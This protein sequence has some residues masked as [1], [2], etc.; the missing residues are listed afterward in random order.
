M[1]RTSKSFLPFLALGV[2]AAV[3]FTASPAFAQAATD[4]ARADRDKWLGLAAALA[5]GLS[6]LGG[7]IG[8]GRA[9]GSALEGIARNP[10]A[11]GKI[12]VPMIVGLALIESLVIYGLLIAFQLFGKIG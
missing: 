7:A 10:Q 3:V 11:S 8:Q 1:R 6:A 4:A 5:I 9:A 2:A 12:F